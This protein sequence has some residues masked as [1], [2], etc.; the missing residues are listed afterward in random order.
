MIF[1]NHSIKAKL[2]FVAALSSSVALLAFSLILFFYETT[3]VKKDLIRNLQI[4][5]NIIAE[6]SLASLA[7]M[8]ET[9]AQK[10]LS[11]LKFNPDILYAGLYNT[12][13]QILGTYRQE[14]YLDKPTFQNNELKQ[15]PHLQQTKNFVQITHPVYLNGELLGYL[16]LNANFS[17]LD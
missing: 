14:N 8:D 5:V 4:Q 10:T 2:I 15:V 9:T 11:A 6:N 7:F 16:V 13:Q 1:R 3:F 12:Q 17:S